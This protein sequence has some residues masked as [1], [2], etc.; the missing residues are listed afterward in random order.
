MSSTDQIKEKFFN[1]YIK[2]LIENIKN[3]KIS[4]FHPKVEQLE[5]YYISRY[6]DKE[7]KVFSLNDLSS[8]LKGVWADNNELNN[9]ELIVSIIKLSEKLYKSENKTD[10]I[11]PFIY[12]M[13]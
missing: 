3:S 11:S 1:K 8:E 6:S 7:E 10:E 4:Y 9:K 12:E 13:F 5:S 2:N